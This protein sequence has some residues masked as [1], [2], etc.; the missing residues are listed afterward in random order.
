MLEVGQIHDRLPEHLELSVLIADR[1]SDLIVGHL[2]RR[3]AP[4]RR[5]GA[6]RAAGRKFGVREFRDVAVAADRLLAGDAAV[7]PGHDAQRL[8]EAVAEIIRQRVALSANDVAVRVAQDDVAGRIEGVGRLVVDDFVGGEVVALVLD[9]DVAARNDLRAVVVVD[10]FVGLQVQ[11]Q[12]AIDLLRFAEHAARRLREGRRLRGRL[13]AD[14]I[15]VLGIGR[16]GGEGQTAGRCERA[17]NS[18]T[19]PLREVAKARCAITALQCLRYPQSTHHS[20]VLL[21]QQHRC[22]GHH[23]QGDGE[24]DCDPRRHQTGSADLPRNLSQ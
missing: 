9:L 5:R 2:A 7:V 16:A 14:G 1:L 18:A 23:G 22:C 10:E 24:P 17:Q 11:R 6:I 4:Q 19:E 3:D 12:R 13:V 8:H 20:A 15:G 21:V